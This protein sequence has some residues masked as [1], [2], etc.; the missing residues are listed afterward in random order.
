MP[1]RAPTSKGSAREVLH[2][3][4][5]MPV[6]LDPLTERK[7]EVLR[8]VAEGAS[9]GDIAAVVVMPVGVGTVK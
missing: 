7:V 3:A 4:P 8:Y 1:A 9:N 2:P 6:V 5:G